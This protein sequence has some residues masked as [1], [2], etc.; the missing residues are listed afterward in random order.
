MIVIVNLKL[1]RTKISWMIIFGQAGTYLGSASAC[2]IV[3]FMIDGKVSWKIVKIDSTI[4]YVSLNS[5]FCLYELSGHKAILSKE[6]TTYLKWMSFCSFGVFHL[7]LHDCR[8]LFKIDFTIAIC[9]YVSKEFGP[10]KIWV[11]FGLD[12]SAVFEGSLEFFAVNLTILIQVEGI[13]SLLE[14]LIAK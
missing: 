13:K 14:I 7:R 9:V 3:F 5:L 6:D 12:A 8:E 2:L 11:F 4:R 10:E 1:E